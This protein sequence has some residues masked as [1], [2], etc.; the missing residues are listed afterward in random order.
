VHVLYEESG[1]FKVGTVLAAT[2]AFELNKGARPPCI[3]LI[4]E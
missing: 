4:S 1:D 2:D 3:S